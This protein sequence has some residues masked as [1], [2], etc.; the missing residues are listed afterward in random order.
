MLEPREHS[1]ATYV[2]TYFRPKPPGART[3][4]DPSWNGA[5]TTECDGTSGREMRRICCQTPLLQISRRRRL[6]L[7]LLV[8]NTGRVESPA[9]SLWPWSFD[10][11]VRRR[12]N[13][14]CHAELGNTAVVRASIERHT[15]RTANH[16]NAEA[17]MRSWSVRSRDEADC[18]RAVLL[19]A[20]H[21]DTFHGRPR[22]CSKQ[23]GALE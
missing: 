11:L 3:T 20:T 2:R 15:L 22:R 9:A 13:D 12:N 6:T 10:R 19:S 4:I 16:A 23:T 21:P 17:S 5:R 7:D 18:D 1:R 14:R 8:P